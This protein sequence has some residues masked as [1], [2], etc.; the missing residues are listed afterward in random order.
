M[1][2]SR[3]EDTGEEDK[4]A[5]ND[6]PKEPTEKTPTSFTVMGGFEN[7]PVQKVWQMCFQRAGP[8]GSKVAISSILVF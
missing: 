6:S 2:S 7:K 3:S 8:L 1:K 5:E 4:E